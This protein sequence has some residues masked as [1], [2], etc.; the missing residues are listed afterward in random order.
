MKHLGERRIRFPGGQSRALSVPRQTHLTSELDR[1][2]NNDISCVL[3][4][5]LLWLPTSFILICFCQLVGFKG[6]CPSLTASP[7]LCELRWCITQGRFRV[8]FPC[9]NLTVGMVC[10]HI[11]K[12][13][14]GYFWV[15]MAVERSFQSIRL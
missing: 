15:Q 10:S 7:R 6:S 13:I 14:V 9:Q 3:G 11:A 1:W 12:A 4:S 2:T 5:W 8:T